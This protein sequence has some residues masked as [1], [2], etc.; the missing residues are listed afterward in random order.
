MKLRQLYNSVT[1][2]VKTNKVLRRCFRVLAV[3]LIMALLAP[4]LAN[5]K[6]LFCIYKDNWLFPAFSYKQTL[7]IDQQTIDYNMG[8]EW[9][10]FDCSFALFPPCAYSPQSID[11]ENAPRKSPFDQ[12]FMKLRNGQVAELPLKFRH[13]LGTTQNGNDVL[14]CL[15]H[16]S[17]VSLSVGIIS[18][19]IASLIGISLG[20]AAGY[21]RDDTYKAGPFQLAG[22]LSGLF[23]TWFYCFIIRG[24]QLSAALEHGSWKLALRILLYMYIGFK[25]IAGFTW[26]GRYIDRKLGIRLSFKIPADSIISRTIE[27]L[28]SIPAL[29][30]IIVV[31][32]IGKPSFM[33]LA[34]IIGG[35]SW[36]SIARIT[37]AEYLK[38]SQLDYVTSCKAI[39][40]SHFRIIRKQIL[41]NV[42]PVVMV[43]IVFGLAGAVLAEASLSF[44]GVGVPPDITTWGSLL[45]EARDHFSAWW[46]VVFPGLC[47]FVLIYTYN[48]IAT[49]LSGRKQSET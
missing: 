24:H 36:T 9:K 6:P 15:I 5:D 41:P 16:G 38:A 44:I 18:M 37:R 23:L 27:I 29:L 26:I 30:L 1:S 11:A 22:L 13:W 28:N 25:T 19:L 46:L 39:G 8:K 3:F 31:S 48:K 35:L 7:T 45:N 40:M 33:L 47:L 4:F 14:S 21:Y 2:L 43:Q 32:A 20:A 42:L 17:R 12:Q 10:Q 49:E 34:L